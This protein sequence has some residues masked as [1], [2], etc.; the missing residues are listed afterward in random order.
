MARK[1]AKLRI[2]ETD[3][4]ARPESDQR[5]VQNA[6]VVIVRSGDSYFGI[7]INVVQEIVLMQEITEIPGS[8]PYMAGM[9]DLRGRVVPVAEFAVLLGNEP[10]E[11]NDDTRILVV[12]HGEGHTGLVV[13]AVTEVTLVDSEK[14]EDATTVGAQ[15]HEFIV[16][17]AK[18]EDRLVSLLDIDRLLASAEKPAARAA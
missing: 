10:S 15:N 2:A 8:P 6:H 1:P 12:E 18:L 4:D 5:T 13:D 14:I 17:V 11:R 7:D 9:T 3:A 16:A